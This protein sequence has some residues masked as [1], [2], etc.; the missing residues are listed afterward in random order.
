MKTVAI[1]ED[2]PDLSELLRYNLEREG[3][4]V[5]GYGSGARALEFCQRSRPDLM[6]LDVMLPEADGLE[7]CKQ[8]RSDRDLKNLPIIFLTARGGETDRVLG[9]ELGGNDYVVKPFSM[10]EL[11]VRVKIQLEGH[12]RDTDILKAGPL[13]LDRSSYQVRLDGQPVPL[14]ATEFRLLEHLMKHPGQVF[15]RDRLL[16]VVWG[17]DRDVLERTVDAY[18]VRLRSKL[19][20]NPEQPRLIHSMRGIGYT[21]RESVSQ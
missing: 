11:L 4:A 21:F 3:Y 14:T 2:D 6:I 17:D 7:V 18:I 1:I 19:E 8:I 13:E 10:R 5:A 20:R 9:L 12:R 15:Q 16:D